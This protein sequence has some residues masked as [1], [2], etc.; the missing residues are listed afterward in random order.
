MQS[1]VG[2]SRS[3]VGQTQ[4]EDTRSFIGQSSRMNVAIEEERNRRQ[5]NC[6]WS[7]GKVVGWFGQQY[8]F[9]V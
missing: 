6:R 5:I 3:I 2:R 8:D 4:S 7:N 9:S 1:E